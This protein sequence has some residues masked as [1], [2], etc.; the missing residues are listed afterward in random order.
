MPWTC[1]AC[2]GPIQHSELE[3]APR[4]G[5]TYRCHICRLELVLDSRSDTLVVPPH[6]DPHGDSEDRQRKIGK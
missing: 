2:R 4:F 5:I 3:K 6:V 1:P